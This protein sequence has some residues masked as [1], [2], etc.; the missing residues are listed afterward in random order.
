[1]GVMLA[2]AVCACGSVFASIGGATQLHPT[3][4]RW[5]AGVVPSRWCW[6]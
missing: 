2:A 3:V 4:R 5:L 1:M 6:R